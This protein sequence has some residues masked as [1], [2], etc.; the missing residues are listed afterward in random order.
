MTKF[1]KVP[2]AEN[3]DKQSI[4]DA[5]TADGYVSFNEGWG[6]DYERDL[7]S[8]PNAK[9]VGRK[10]M[11][12]VLNAITAAIRQYQTTGF[13]EF[14]TAA[15][16]GGTAYPY[17]AGTVVQYAGKLYVSLIANNTSVPGTDSNWQAFIYKRAAQADADAG[18]DNTLIITPP[19]MKQSISDAM[20]NIATD[21]SPYLLPVGVVVAWG[22]TVPP[23]G[24]I[25]ANGQAFDRAK[26]PKLLAVYPSG[27][28]PDLRGRFVRGWAHGSTADPEP[29][30][31]V[32][33]EQ[34]AADLEHY[35]YTGRLWDAAGRNDDIWLINRPD[36]S[37]GQQFGS[38]VITG[39]SGWS[40]LGSYPQSGTGQFS[41][42]GNA[43]KPSGQGGMPDPYPA[44]TALM[45]I[46]KTDGAD[47]IK[48][49]P[50]PTNIIVT[51][52]A[53]TVG[54][55]ATQ[56]FTAQVFP[57]DLAAKFPVTWTSSNSAIGTVSAAGLFTAKAAG[58]T[59]IIA[60]VSSGLS[61]RV[62]VRVDVLL[63]AIALAAIPN[64]VTGNTYTLQ[65]TKTPSN[66]TEVINYASTDNAVA[67]AS[68]AGVLA[69]G[70]AGTA[71]ISVTGAVSGKT[72][73]RP[74][75]VT[76]AP[77]V[78]EWLAIKNNLSEIA[79]A[80]AA[81]QTAARNN[82]GLKALATK[83]SLTAG[84]VGAVPL[85]GA[86]M[87]AG[88][89]LNNMT[90][91]GQYF[92]NVTSNATLALNY[93]EAVAGSLEVLKT[94][95]DT[96]G[97][98]QVYRPY[99]STAEYQR[100]G[101]GSPFAWGAWGKTVTGLSSA[102]DSNREDIAATPAAIFALASMIGGLGDNS[103]IDENGFWRHAATGFMIQWGFIDASGTGSSVVTLPRPYTTKHFVT[104]PSVMRSSASD[105]SMWNPVV[106]EL[107][108]SSV[109][110]SYGSGESKLYWVSIGK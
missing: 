91:P 87:P 44:N 36:D 32:L 38:F 60:S 52:S 83:D 50:T 3:G 79:A 27:N 22:S 106:S 18:T 29:G 63:T 90:T 56:Q 11:N 26:N 72:T 70:S 9:P 78:A 10:E 1:F 13:P 47:N 21:L 95:V 81:A 84:D 103:Q 25:E 43:I 7:K 54:V 23:D 16:N 58:T 75:T 65:V 46:V 45:Y 15:D 40:R 89:N 93:P 82:L 107:G 35:H 76:A 74:V 85:A 28:V 37:S 53:L 33:S 96:V 12:G 110:I 64:Q 71:T 42:T 61:V 39:D 68:A 66:A 67:S 73:S 5:S 31:G 14:I 20:S 30:R 100:Y 8:D 57:A 77:V 69:A 17:S 104:I 51:P 48:P 59:D 19:V 62:T 4:P 92:Q 109:R 2:F 88:T 24:W 34:A 55:G 99:N 102:L 105:N 80:G 97:S 41:G 49:D 108:L 98:R 101:F 94:G 6:G 86:A